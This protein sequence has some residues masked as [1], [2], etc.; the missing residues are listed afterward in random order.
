VDE[1]HSVVGGLVQFAPG[2]IGE[3]DLVKAPA[4]FRLERANGVVGLALSGR[5]VASS[6]PWV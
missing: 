6:G 4:E 2:F 1:E 5:S 3:G